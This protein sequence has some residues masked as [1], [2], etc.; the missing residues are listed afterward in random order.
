MSKTRKPTRSR[1]RFARSRSRKAP[2][3]VV[4]T[5]Y[6]ENR[7]TGRVTTTHVSQGSCPLTCPHLDNGCYTEGGPLGIITRRLNDAG[8]GYTPDELA[9]MEAASIRATPAYTDMRLHVVG[10]SRTRRAARILAAAARDYAKRG[11]A[12]DVVVWKY[13]HA[14]ETVPSSDWK[15]V[16][17]LASVE[18]FDQAERAMA[19]DYAVAIILSKFE[20]FTPDG[21]AFRVELSDGPATVIPCPFQTRGIQCVRCRLCLDSDSLRENRQIIAFEA[22]GAGQDRVRKSLEVI[23]LE[24]RCQH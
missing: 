12:F 7:K 20:D 2:S 14:W 22:H 21:K 6:S 13:T 9:E 1:P 17:I 24:N 18:S 3:P 5:P 8:T 15:G 16:S 4:V 10:D 23:S 19:K 11:R